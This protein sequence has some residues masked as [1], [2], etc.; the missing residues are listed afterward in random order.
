MVMKN[1]K[2]PNFIFGI[3]TILLVLIGIGLKA[4]GYRFGDHV[5]IGSTILGGIHWIW[6]IIDVTG[7]TDMKPFQK[8]FWLILVV[9]VPALGALLFYMLHQKADK[10]TT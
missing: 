8:R 9:A 1:T 10:I 7:R 6:G 2:S 5:L 3:I 4:N